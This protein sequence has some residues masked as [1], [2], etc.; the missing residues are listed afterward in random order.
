MSSRFGY[1]PHADA[2]GSDLEGFNA[3]VIPCCFYYSLDTRVQEFGERKA[4]ILDNA[5]SSV[6]MRDTQLGSQKRMVLNHSE[7]RDVNKGRE[8]SSGNARLRRR[9]H[10]ALDTRIC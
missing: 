5:A 8:W 4:L 2:S 1:L 3:A 10:A 9:S 6:Y 7:E